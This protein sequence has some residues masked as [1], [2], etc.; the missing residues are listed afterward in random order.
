MLNRCDLHIVV[1]MTYLPAHTT[2]FVI[3]PCGWNFK[4]AD[5]ETFTA[6][7]KN[8]HNPCTWMERKKK[9]KKLLQ[10]SRGNAVA[11]E[12]QLVCHNGIIAV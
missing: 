6:T 9:L 2:L 3:L 7:L 12:P 5:G 11:N 4:A 1:C 8:A 10:I